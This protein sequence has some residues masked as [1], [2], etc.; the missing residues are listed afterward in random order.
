MSRLSSALAAAALLLAVAP[1]SAQ[2]LTRI[3]TKPFY[4]AVVTI[5]GGV[6]V[7]RPLPPTGQMIINPGGRTPLS[8]SINEYRDYS[9]A[10][11]A[12]VPVSGD[13][14]GSDAGRARGLYLNP[15]AGG[16]GRRGHHGRFG[17]GGG[18]G[19]GHGNRYVRHINGMPLG[20][21]PR[22]GRNGGLSGTGGGKGGGHGGGHR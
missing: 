4:G 14:E 2:T 3:E 22:G 10:G 16:W 8:V 11:V 9:G 5:E 20:A 17:Q 6:R 21:A 18:H 7:F 15:W 12:G 13:Y 1:A 19:H